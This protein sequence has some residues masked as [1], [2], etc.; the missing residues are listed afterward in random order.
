[1][2]GPAT[3]PLAPDFTYWDGVDP[4]HFL[5]TDWANPSRQWAAGKAIEAAKG[6]TLLEVGPGPGVEYADW[7][8]KS[9]VQYTGVEGSA[10][11]FRALCERF[12]ETSWVHGQ[13]AG[14]PAFSADVVYARHVLEHQP[15]LEPA[16]GTLLA[17]AR[18]AVL[19]TWYR[20]PG[21][22]AFHEVLRGVYRHTY[23]REAVLGQIAL[24]GCRVAE[25][26]SFPTGDECWVMVKG[27][28]ER[29]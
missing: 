9:A 11:L 5:E 4:A 2:T 23:E 29:I 14:L 24:H 12:P 17:A 19:L 3:A 21:P 16:L 1:M 27:D 15:T 25:S 26:Q 6:G 7:F 18:S 10:N 28:A 13:I 8:S 22:V 20:P